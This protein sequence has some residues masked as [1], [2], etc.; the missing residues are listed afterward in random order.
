MA[1]SI[2]SF[3]KIDV[4]AEKRSKLSTST[5]SS[6]WRTKRACSTGLPKH[7]SR[8]LMNWCVRSSFRSKVEKLLREVIKEYKAKSPAFPQAGPEPAQS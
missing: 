2:C 1:E 5:S 8:I 6:G 3:H 4:Y 7:Q